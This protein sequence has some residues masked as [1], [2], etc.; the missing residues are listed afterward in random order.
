[1]DFFDPQKQKEHAIRL[2]VGYALIAVVL[3]LATTILLYRAR[4]F[5]L[6]KN[7]QVIQNGLVFV[8]S[9]PSSAAVYVNGRQYKDRTNTRMEIPGGQ[10]VME[11]KKGGYRTW[12]RS[13][14][15]EGGRVE[16]FHYP[17]LVPTKPKTVTTKQ[18]A[19]APSVATESPDRRWLLMAAPGQ[20]VFDLFDLD[21]DKLVPQ[22]VAV[23]NDILAAGSTTKGWVVS[24]WAKDNRHL[25]LQR[26]YDRLGQPGTEYIL[27]DREDPTLSQNLS[28]ILG[29]TP[30]A[31]ELRGG[32]F[33][34]YYAFDQASGQVFTASLKRPTPQPYIRNVV[35]FTSEGTTTLFVT[36][37]GAPA[38]KVLVRMQQGDTTAY[39]IRQLPAGTTYMLEMASYSDELYA[40]VGS[41]SEGRVYVFK[42]PIGALKDKPKDPV[43][44]VQL[45]KVAAPSHVSF[46][47]NKRFV[48]AENGDRFAVYD[49]ETDQGYAYQAKAPLDA[50]QTHATWMDAFRI[51]YVS[52]GKQI[53]MDYDG[54]NSQDIA[55]ASPN[56]LPFFDRDYRFLYSLNSQNV[57][58]ATALRTAEDL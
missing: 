4:G 38:G 44:P 50:P 25:L 29:F 41:Q 20:N 31:I 8:S 40:A 55:P 21:A 52:G 12:K 53:V 30:T 13:L 39:T 45:L 16:R 2:A 22:T 48:M 19:A 18:Y 51:A 58:T 10:Y 35:D 56:Y 17:F 42:D 43:I 11:I 23:S 27:L 9:T 24:D 5:G 14:P 46:S 33:D 26:T 47:T 34:N 28:V 1:M 49:A 3:I 54:T 37:E 57:F 36:A 7:G 15:V 6:D 32:A